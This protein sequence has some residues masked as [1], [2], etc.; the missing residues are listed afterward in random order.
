MVEELLLLLDELLELVVELLVVVV[1]APPLPPLPVPVSVAVGAGVLEPPLLPGSSEQPLKAT[2]T[3]MQTI[4][5]QV[6]HF[7]NQF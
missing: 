1:P 5:K 4:A 6:H 7:I 3:K 2:A